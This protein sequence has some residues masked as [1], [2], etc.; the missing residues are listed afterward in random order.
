MSSRVGVCKTTKF[1]AKR[2]NLTQH[3]ESPCYHARVHAP[4][5]ACVHARVCRCA[6]CVRL[7][8]FLCVRECAGHMHACAG[9]RSVRAC[10]FVRSLHAGVLVRAC[11]G[12][13]AQAHA[14]GSVLS[15]VIPEAS[16]LSEIYYPPV[17]AVTVAYPKSAFKSPELKGF[18]SLNP[19]S[20]GV[21]TLGTIWSSSL[22]PGR[23]P[24]GYNL[25]LNY[26]GGSRD[27]EIAKLTEEEIIAEVSCRCVL[28]R[29]LEMQFFD[30]H[31]LPFTLSSSRSY[32]R[33]HVRACVRTY[34][35]AL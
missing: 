11:V 12:V 33:S 18:G 3:D 19:R 27:P 1:H 34:A 26:I 35:F 2:R 16:R 21:R 10:A 17:A 9:Q 30:Q 15:A 25:L 29:S 8:A 5:R 22:F 24:E 4:V 13:R 14:I 31:H 32:T 6:L 7:C 28:R 23:A 20:E